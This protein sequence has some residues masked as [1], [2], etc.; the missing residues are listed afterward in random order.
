MELNDNTRGMNDRIRE[1][2]TQW[3]GADPVRSLA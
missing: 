2:A 1:A 3:D